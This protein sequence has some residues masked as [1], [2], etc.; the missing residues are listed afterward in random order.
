MGDGKTKLWNKYFPNL[1]CLVLN[2]RLVDKEPWVNPIVQVSRPDICGRQKKLSRL[3]YQIWS[4][5]TE[6]IYSC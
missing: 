3:Y 1:T 6:F 4:I 5:I 2:I